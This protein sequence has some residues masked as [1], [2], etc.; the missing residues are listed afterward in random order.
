MNRTELATL[1]KE[2]APPE[3]AATFPKLALDMIDEWIVRGDV[4]CIYRNE[5]LG[6]PEAGHV[7]FVSWGG[8]EAQL[9]RTQFAEIPRTLPDIGDK[10]NWR[11]QLLDTYGPFDHPMDTAEGDD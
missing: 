1:L 6:H 9:E 8:S 11:Y 2:I 3:D 5:E 4:C 7:Q 10:I